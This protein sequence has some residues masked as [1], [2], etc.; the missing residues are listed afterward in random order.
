MMI[1][2]PRLGN[3]C[4]LGAPL[5]TQVS[6]LFNQATLNIT[7]PSGYGGYGTVPSL[8]CEKTWMGAMVNDAHVVHYSD[9][10]NGQIIGIDKS[11]WIHICLEFVVLLFM[12]VILLPF[13]AILAP[14]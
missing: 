10:F 4:T 6:T 8:S 13:L 9:A 12:L 14:I 11:V 1:I 7:A 2:L 5:P 3:V